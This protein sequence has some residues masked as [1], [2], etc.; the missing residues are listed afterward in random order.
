MRLSSMYFV[1]E[2]KLLRTLRHSQSVYRTRTLFSSGL[3]TY[4]TMKD[5]KRIDHGFLGGYLFS[6]AM[7]ALF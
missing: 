3:L 2:Y 6:S 7:D 4:W 1:Q 5:Q